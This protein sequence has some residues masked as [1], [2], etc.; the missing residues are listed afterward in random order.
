MYTLYGLNGANSVKTDTIHEKFL[1][2]E[3]KNSQQTDVDY[4]TQLWRPI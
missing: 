3:K 1:I 2:R 4:E